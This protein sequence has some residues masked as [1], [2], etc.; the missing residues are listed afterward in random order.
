MANYTSVAQT[1]MGQPGQEAGSPTVVIQLTPR[2]GFIFDNPHG[3]SI[4]D[5]EGIFDQED[6]DRNLDGSVTITVSLRDD[7]DFPS[8]DTNVPIRISGDAVPD[9][10]TVDVILGG[11]G[12]DSDGDGTD[13]VDIHFEDDIGNGPLGNLDIDV[14][15]DEGDEFNVGNVVMCPIADRRFMEDANGDIILPNIPR[16]RDLGN[17]AMLVYSNPRIND[18]GC[19]V[20]T[21]TV[22]IGD[23]DSDGTE[24]GGEGTDLTDGGGNGG[25][26]EGTFDDIFNV[27]E[28]GNDNPTG[29]GSEEIPDDD[30]ADAV[31]VAIF[32]ID[33][34]TDGL[35]P[36]EGGFITITA[37]GTPGATGSVTL[38]PNVIGTGTLPD[39]VGTIVVDLLIENNGIDVVFVRIPSAAGDEN[40]S[41]LCMP[42]LPDNVDGI[43]WDIEAEED[44]PDDPDTPFDFDLDIDNIMQDEGSSVYFNI[45]SSD[46]T[47]DL[48]DGAFLEG[49]GWTYRDSIDGDRG[50]SYSDGV[51][52]AII[53][54]G[55]SA[56][57]LLDANSDDVVEIDPDVDI[58]CDP[59]INPNF[60]DGTVTINANGDLV[61]RQPY[62][63]GVIPQ[64][65]RQCFIDL[66]NLATRNTEVIVRW[67]IPD[68][69]NYE[70]AARSQ[71]EF[72]YSGRPGETV[73]VGEVPTQIVLTAN[74]GF[75]WQSTDISILAANIM[76]TGTVGASHITPGN[77]TFNPTIAALQTEEGLI[78]E[79]TISW[80][81]TGVYPMPAM[82]IEDIYEITPS[83]GTRRIVTNTFDFGDDFRGQDSLIDATF[84]PIAPIMGV[85]TRNWGPVTYTI[86]ADDGYVFKSGQTVNGILHSSTHTAT[87]SSGTLASGDFPTTVTGTISGTF[88]DTNDTIFID[89]EG[90]AFREVS[91]TYTSSETDSVVSIVA[92]FNGTVNGVEGENAPTRTIT[93]RANSGYGFSTLPT[94]NTSAG[95]VSNIRFIGTPTNVGGTDYYSN[96]SADVDYTFTG[97]DD[98]LVNVTVSGDFAVLIPAT[99]VVVTN[100]GTVPNI[101]D[102]ADVSRVIAD[103]NGNRIVDDSVTLEF[104]IYTAEGYAWNRRAVVDDHIEINT[105]T[106]GV[107]TNI[108][109]RMADGTPAGDLEENIGGYIRVRVT[110]TPPSSTV[111]GSTVTITYNF[112][113]PGPTALATI[114][115]TPDS[116]SF[117]S[118]AFGAANSQ[119]VT[120]NLDNPA[121]GTDTITVTD[122]ANF[123]VVAPANINEGAN[124]VYSIYPTAENT[125]VLAD[126]TAIVTFGSAQ[127]TGTTDTVTLTQSRQSLALE[128]LPAVSTIAQ[129]INSTGNFTITTNGDWTI[130]GLDTA[131]FSLS[132]TSG[133]AGTHTITANAL[134]ANTNVGDTAIASAIADQLVVTSTATGQTDVTHNVTLRQLGLVRIINTDG[135]GLSDF[136]DSVDNGGGDQSLDIVTNDPALTWTAVETADADG[137]ISGLTTSGTGSSTLSYTVAS[138]GIDEPAKTATIT[139]TFSTGDTQV[140]TVSLAA[141]TPANYNINSFNVRNNNYSYPAVG[142]RASGTSNTSASLPTSSNFA[143]SW[144]ASTSDSWISGLSSSGNIGDNI[145]FTVNQQS[146]G[147]GERTGTIIVSWATPNGT[148]NTIV[149]VMQAAGE[150]VTFEL[151]GVDGDDTSD[152]SNTG[153]MVSVSTNSNLP[154]ATWTAVE[155]TDSD[156]IISSLSGSG[157]AGTPITYTVAANAAGEPAK[158][159]T[160]TVT[161]SD[162]TVRT[163]TVNLAQGAAVPATEFAFS[164]TN[165]LGGTGT[166]ADINV[167]ANGDWIIPLT[168]NSGNNRPNGLT[169]S[170]SD[171]SVT[172]ESDNTV[173]GNGNASL[174]F[175]TTEIA[176]GSLI[177][178]GAT[179]NRTSISGSSSE[180]NLDQVP[181]FS[182]ASSFLATEQAGTLTDV[183]GG[184]STGVFSVSGT[185]VRTGNAIRLGSGT[186]SWITGLTRPNPSNNIYNVTIDSNTGTASRTGSIVVEVYEASNA[187]DGRAITNGPTVGTR[188]LTVTQDREVLM[189]TFNNT[190]VG[191]YTVPSFN[192]NGTQAFNTLSGFDVNVG[193]GNTGATHY[194]VWPTDNAQ[195]D[196]GVLIYDSIS[197]PYA[198]FYYESEGY[199]TSSE[200]WAR[201]VSMTDPG[202]V[203]PIA[204]LDDLPGLVPIDNNMRIRLREY[205]SPTADRTATFRI[206]FYSSSSRDDLIG[207]NDFTITQERNPGTASLTVNGVNIQN[208]RTSGVAA[209]VPSTIE[210]VVINLP[211]DAGTN[212]RSDTGGI[213]ISFTTSFGSTGSLIMSTPASPI[214]GI[215]GSGTAN[216]TNAD[217]YYGYDSELG[218]CVRGMFTSNTGSSGFGDISWAAV[219]ENGDSSGRIVDISTGTYSATTTSARL[220]NT[221]TFGVNGRGTFWNSPNVTGDAIHRERRVFFTIYFQ[222]DSTPTELSPTWNTFGAQVIEIR[223]AADSTWMA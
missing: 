176:T 66:D 200:T 18:E 164:P 24:G 88:G 191:S 105:N 189:L 215:T 89:G 127:F 152:V 223:Q 92:G 203:W 96:V 31:E 61:V 58:T 41:P 136:T 59:G 111:G 9:V 113:G 165:E 83:G 159:A 81:I 181:I 72:R 161:L 12:G 19:V 40:L 46:D 51:I 209:F 198:R 108:S 98:Q 20:Y 128:V 169:I 106:G 184:G 1:I 76:H 117:D 39:S 32:S 15:G 21:L 2:D 196:N 119:N 220:T 206:S 195:Q 150:T 129:P 123:T 216:R 55:D 14:E 214:A 8:M 208:G 171:A 207:T 53:P 139:I 10:N 34:N 201:D 112:T 134:T 13:D 146:V 99:L 56:W 45:V 177:T 48:I 149:N 80:T 35:D 190:D 100:E 153:G 42:E 121:A 193:A 16:P 187:T 160:I 5:T 211:I 170:S 202:Y 144:A 166:G 186:S 212:A 79:L 62:S 154:G 179:A 23:S 182:A 102:V 60:C 204:Q 188:T 156:N 37:T 118:D 29:G 130:T 194:F 7:I 38:T 135:N 44:N 122:P 180:N 218:Y 70:I 172:I 222:W 43:Q 185:L 103:S 71:S 107:S 85:E 69:A 78:T 84:S 162:G 126:R 142:S 87:V 199:A 27:D 101:M 91:V 49:G 155:T 145:T 133:S 22:V 17:G 124:R 90:D 178:G 93:F 110:Y 26:G 54:A 210:P 158:T 63:G 94:V 138:N 57:I 205:G 163:I 148:V 157:S 33:I 104:R 192:S 11:G 141:G 120:V 174:T 65:I 77:L 86:T 221:G 213:P 109:V 36:V 114:N 75:T 4:I 50:F 95:T 74:D 116:L 167:I 217:T 28:D 219:Y 25:G 47:I 97:A 173:L 68:G 131:L 175:T 52:E 115:A 151:D 132:A 73:D 168:F 30:D 147:A 6:I 67:N 183:S 125:S 82:V 64:D 143:T 3:L 137:I 140:I 197:S